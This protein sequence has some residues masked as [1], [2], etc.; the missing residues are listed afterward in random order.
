MLAVIASTEKL[1]WETGLTFSLGLI[2]RQYKIDE[3]PHWQQVEN[4]VSI[5]YFFNYY[6][7]GI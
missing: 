3:R 1:H 2:F 4:F 5:D 6:I 7:W